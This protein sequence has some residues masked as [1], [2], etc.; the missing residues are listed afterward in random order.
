MAKGYGYMQTP[1]YREKIRQAKMIT[2]AQGR[3]PN[4]GEL[5]L[6]S[7]LDSLYPDQFIYNGDF[8]Q[9]I[10]LNG[11]VPDFVNINGRKQVI[12][13][14]GA[15]WH[16]NPNEEVDKIQAYGKIGWHCLIIWDYEMKNKL[17]LLAKISEFVEV[18][19]NR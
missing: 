5:A 1:E 7:I 15:Y 18:K 10:L 16:N 13:Y 6:Y 4:K 14:F 11:M 8:S 2:R 3:H 12:E 17:A 9:R 19:A